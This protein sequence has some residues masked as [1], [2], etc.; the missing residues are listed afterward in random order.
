MRAFFPKIRALFFKFWKRA[1]ETF[2]PS[3]LLVTRL[4]LHS[5]AFFTFFFWCFLLFMF[6][7]FPRNLK[8]SEAA[9]HMISRQNWLWK[10]CNF[11]RSLLSLNLKIYN[12]F[13]N[14]LRLFDVLP[15]FPFTTSEMMDDY[16]LWT[17]YIRVASGL[18]E[19]F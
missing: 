14:I 6:S 15:S 8:K 17:W 4:N 5:W 10:F 16:Y 2:L 1:G 9:I 3:P 19:Q 13:H 12:R 11:Q 18:A 7:I